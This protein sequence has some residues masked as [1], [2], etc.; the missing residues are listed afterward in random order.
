MTIQTFTDTQIDVQQFASLHNKRVRNYFKPN[1]N[2]K[3]EIAKERAYLA[4]RLIIDPTKSSKIDCIFNCLWFDL[5]IANAFENVAKVYGTPIRQFQSEVAFKP[6]ICFTFKEREINKQDLPLRN[7]KL[8]KEISFRLNDVN[9][10]K[11]NAQLKT[12]AQKIKTKF[13]TSGR[14]YNYN[15]GLN[16]YRYKDDDNGYRLSIDMASTTKAKELIDKLL[17]IQNV[18][19]V[20]S[21]LRTTKFTKPTKVELIPTVNGRKQKPI[22]GRTGKLYLFKVEFKQSGIIDKIL[23]D[24]MGNITV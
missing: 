13:W 19:Y 14:A 1:N 10:P 17:D 22:R 18:K 3:S 11:T 2:D 8:E 23:I 21:K 15:A 4:S 7:Y 5:Q 9:V 16:N 6:Q 12:L 20:E 24:Q